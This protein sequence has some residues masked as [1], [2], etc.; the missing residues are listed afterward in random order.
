MP[1]T[2]DQ[3]PFL[4][5]SR[6]L[7]RPE[8]ARYG[9]KSKKFNFML[10]FTEDGQPYVSAVDE[11]LKRFTPDSALYSGAERTCL[12]E[13]EK[14]GVSAAGMIDWGGDKDKDIEGVALAGHPELMRA[15][16]LCDNVVDARGG[17]IDFARD[18]AHVSLV[19]KGVED[20]PGHMSGSIEM[21]FGGET[22]HD[23]RFIGDSFA[24]AG[25]TVY[26]LQPVGANFDNLGAFL[27]PFSES[28]LTDMLSVF[29]SYVDNITPRVE[30]FDI[31][32]SK[33]LERVTPTI[34]FD[35][36][37]SDKALY[38]RIVPTISNIPDRMT[39]RFY[40]TKVVSR[41][42]NSLV[43]KNVEPF[44]MEERRDEVVSLIERCA[45]TRKDAREVY[46]D[47]DFLIIP[48]GT[49]SNFLFNGLPQLLGGYR[50]IGADKLSSY[51]IKAVRPKLSMNLSSGIDFLEGSASVELGDQTLTL[52]DLLSS[53]SAKKYV[54]LADGNRAIID[55]TYMK[56]L[57]RI[58]RRADRYGNVKVSF[59]DLPEIDDLLEGQL[60]G[61]GVAHSRE[62]YEGF[63]RLHSE[64]FVKP[65]GLKATLRPYQEEGVKW[66]G[67]LRENGFG[68]CLA[69]DMGL[70]KTVQ[71]IAALLSAPRDPMEPTLLVM[72]RSLIFN[73]E[74][75]LKKFAPALKYHVYYGPGRD[76]EDAL[77]ADVVLTTYAIVRN[78]IE[79][80][81][82]V[83]FGYVVLDE[84]QN[85]KNV[86]AQTT[87][88]V[89]LLHA[90]HRLALS[91]TPIE[92][93]LTELYSLFRF[94]NPTM[95]GTLDD[96]NRLY[97]GPVQREGDEMAAA[98]LR[99]KVFPFIMR[100]M[101]RD[102]LTDLPDRI[103]QS[104][105]VEMSPEQAALYERRRL[106]CLDNINRAIATEGIERSQMLIIQALSELRR[107]ASVPESL[108]EGR[109]T[110]PK[111]EM[112]TEQIE[113]AVGNGHKVVVF[114][115][116]IAGLEI[117]AE[118]LGQAGI[119]CETMTGATVNRGRVVE[120]FTNDPDCR[121][122]LMTLKT[123]GV[124]LNLTVADTVI[125]FEPWWNK[126]AEEQA[127]NRLHRIGQ[128]STVMSFF[129]Y[130]RGT[131]EEK[132]RE[133]Q[134]RK[135]LLVDSVISTD[136]TLGKHISEEDINFILSPS[137]KV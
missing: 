23:A 77:Q 7:V 101:K 79:R 39:D 45:P 71:T 55:E 44:D 47:G 80:L 32:Y 108:S 93:N 81:R 134:E 24:M 89:W 17:R 76:L 86:S 129:I 52:S 6:P 96:F 119:E 106:S 69:D 83:S 2:K 46:R 98:Q 63:N 124:G 116:F 1:Q 127:V 59:F 42:G 72:P 58:F 34:V 3:V 95:F 135:S 111:I 133:L 105:T 118:R 92:N 40:F 64:A 136:S 62:V 13:M 113:S 131:I 70:G 20:D 18:K 97:T 10:S 68:G 25:S 37:D 38:I 109:I 90:R 27:D 61:E 126:A 73:W 122:L 8:G 53:Y 94:L 82:E 12:K 91:G 125:I 36:V 56:R 21:T 4:R 84:S 78:D 115:N 43:V 120:R 130:T 103:D 114:F 9:E 65:L 112:L 123:G 33:V 66:I 128:K 16:V 117:A 60:T 104:M 22:L 102:V 75:E 67:Y 14:A 41:I 121:V 87:Q 54:E 11:S 100:R 51:K 107:I 19:V 49:A 31:S 85:I 137:Q 88:A 29:L 99:R 57:E 74:T 30:G 26:P 132:I 15:L 110:S 5:F 35:K 28:Q 48:E 50:V